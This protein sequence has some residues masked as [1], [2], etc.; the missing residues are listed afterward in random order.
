MMQDLLFYRT[1]LL[2]RLPLMAA[3]FLVV[4]AAAV[5][6]AMSRAPSYTASARL[7]IEGPQIATPGASASNQTPAQLELEAVQQQLLTRTN[8]LEIASSH[9]VFA[10]APAMSPEQVTAIMRTRITIQTSAT[11]QS[12][13]TMRIAF[14]AGDGQTAADVVNDLVARI[15][16]TNVEQRTGSASDTEA[17]FQQEVDRLAL[18]LKAQSDRIVAFQNENIEA[19]PDNR[20]YRASRQLALQTQIA[21][22]N[23]TI[24]TVESQRQGLLALYAATGQVGIAGAGP[25]GMVE[26]QE[27]RS[28]RAQL[29][30]AEAVYSPD[31]AR[32]RSLRAQVQVLEA[33]QPA[34]EAPAQPSEDGSVTTGNPVLDLQLSQLQDQRDAMVQQAGEL[35]AEIQRLDETIRNTP[36]NA[37]ALNILQRDYDSLQEQ[38]ERARLS[39]AQAASNERIQSASKG[40]RITVIEQAVPPEYPTGTS[41]T[42]IALAGALAGVALAVG[43]TL[44]IELMN[45]TVRR[46]SDLVRQF[47]ITPLAT[48]PYMT[49]AEESARQTS[50]RLVSVAATAI[51]ICILAYLVDSFLIPLDLVMSKLTNAAG[52]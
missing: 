51:A 20:E 13:P 40:Q 1:L 10:G 50:Q 48:I 52:F 27:L 2:R 26:S 28:A 39:L 3:I 24:A 42:K 43:I 6:Y 30:Q 44:L 7:M 36:N 16:A 22:L 4:T 17:F 19:L 29:A 12:L 23:R 37:V 47:D 41:R 8:L 25:T 38:Y 35:E 46:S 9:D 49:T 18:E 32:V 21:E 5:A 34:E 11:Y 45:R 33:Q 14:A 15:L 31:S